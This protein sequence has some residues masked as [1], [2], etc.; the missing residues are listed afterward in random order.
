[1]E[2]MMRNR[3]GLLMFLLML[4]AIG[5]FLSPTAGWASILGSPERSLPDDPGQFNGIYWG[6]F[7]GELKDMRLVSSDPAHSGELYYVRPDDVLRLGNAK[8]E[9]VQY[10]FWKGI[11][12][13]FAYGVRGAE[14]WEEL[15]RICFENFGLWHKPNRYVETYYWVGRHSAMTLQYNE[16]MSEGQLYVY[17]KVIYERQI[18]RARQGANPRSDKG[19]WR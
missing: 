6:Q 4:I 13:S 8:L 14:N 16:V 18:A 11:Y 19:F 3:K 1:M 15:K 12:S 7:L 10:G 5:V 17:S 9:Y 2:R